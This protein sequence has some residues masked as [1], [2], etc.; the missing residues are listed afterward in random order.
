MA[1]PNAPVNTPTLRHAPG[2]DGIRAL[3]VIAVVVYHLGTTGVPQLLRGGFLGV[4]VFFV[5]SGYLITSLLLVEVGRT[6]RISMA[7][8]YQR[9]ARRLLPALLAVL[10]AVGGFG[11]F[12]LTDLA[13][14]LRGELVAALG[15]VSN[16]WLIAQHSSY[17]GGGGR[18]SPLTHLWSLAVEEQF[19]LVWPVVLIVLVRFGAQ[20]RGVL[21]GLAVAITASTIAGALLYDPWTDPS[22]VYYGTDTRALAPLIG[23][24]LALCLRPW[25]YGS[26]QDGGARRWLDPAGVGALLAL[27]AIAALLKDNSPLVYRGGFAVIAL[28]AAVVVGVAGHP[29]SRLGRL[30][31]RAPLAWLGERSYAIYLWHWPVFVLTRP[32]LD[33]PLTG[34]ADVALRL[35]ITLVLAELSYRC[36]ERPFRSPRT[37]VVRV[38]AR[39]NAGAGVYRRRTSRHGVA[40]AAVAGVLAAI[41][42]FQLT[43]V[44]GTTTPSVPTDAG[45]APTLGLSGGPAASRG[46]PR[47]AVFGDSQGMTLLVNKPADL[48]RYLTVTDATIEGCGVLTGKVS[49]RSGERRDLG[50]SCGDWAARWGAS[51]AKLKPQIALVMIGAWELFDLTTG[52]GTL[53]FATPQWDA[54]VAAALQQGIAKLSASGAIVAL[55]L[56]PCYRPVRGSAGY[57]PERGDDTRTRHVNDLLRAAAGS[58]KTVRVI[59]PPAQFCT[60]PKIASNTDYRWD[61]VHYY[62]PGAALY[63]E[64][65]IPQLVQ[66]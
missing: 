20:R 11:S 35:A 52:D 58:S 4:D 48:N 10:L 14:K 36:V 66:L 26:V 30:L 18:P 32:G 60:D 16:W 41:V 56:L 51:A 29:A 28:L 34:W 40:L 12:V 49:S 21:I 24:A 64:A 53:T 7:G 47:V 2:L 33:L 17:F 43:A 8:F 38:R 6:G 13:A 61:G 46:I 5:L 57:W 22:R 65:V 3:A 42:G 50:A 45:P 54:A 23:A 39:Q 44:A 37:V 55:A 63:F 62:K 25:R 31:G 15:Y 27:A 19:Y 1:S 9:R 59:E